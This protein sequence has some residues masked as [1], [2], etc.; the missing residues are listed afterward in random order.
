MVDVMSWTR[1][2][3]AS[4]LRAWADEVEAK[5]LVVVETTRSGGSTRSCLK[6][7]AT[8]VGGR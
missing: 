7:I 4:D 3:R 5:D 2:E 6:F 8:G 1:A